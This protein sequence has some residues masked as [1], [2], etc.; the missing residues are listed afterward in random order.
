MKK[1]LLSLGVIIAATL[2]LTSCLGSSNSEQ[3]YTFAY[4]PNDCFNRV[5]DNETG[6][7]YIGMN[8]TYNIVFNMTSSQADIDI[9]NLKLDSSYPAISLRLPTL[10]LK[11]DPNDGF[12]TVSGN[13]IVPQGLTSAYVFSTFNFRSFPF[14]SIPAYVINYTVND[15]YDVT[16]YPTLPTYVGSVSATNLKPEDGKDPVFNLSPDYEGYYQLLINPEKMTA[17]LN[18]ANAKFASGMS[19]YNFA[20]RDLPVVLTANG[21]RIETE[22]GKDYNIYSPQSVSSPTATPIPGCTISDIRV[23]ATLRTGATIS[24][25]CDLGDM[26]K[27]S[28]QANLRY[29]IYNEENNKN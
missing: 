17:M 26:G 18:V 29:L 3:K 11:Q 15:R 10:P 21:F 8:P 20:T 14:R 23:Y 2:S 4:G 28:V 16:V 5:V 24:F 7:S 9:S 19:R 1:Y 27:Y 13:D 25:T 12:Y 22:L 6:E